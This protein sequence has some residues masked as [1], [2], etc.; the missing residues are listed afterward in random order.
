M[1]PSFSQEHMIGR[2]LAVHHLANRQPVSAILPIVETIGIHTPSQ[3]SLGMVLAPRV[4]GFDNGMVTPL[5]ESGRLIRTLGV[6]GAIRVMSSGEWQFM[7]EELTPLDE[8][9]LLYMVMG[10][11]SLL[12]RLRMSAMQVLNM[13]C[14]VLPT[15]LKDGRMNKTSLGQAVALSIQESLNKSEREIWSWPSF[16]YQGQ[17]LGESLVRHLL[18][19]AALSVPVRLVDDPKSNGF[20]YTIGSGDERWQSGDGG[21]LVRRFLHAY[22]PADG[23][24]FAMWAR[25]SPSHASRL[26]NRI[27]KEELVKIPGRDKLDWMLVTDVAHL[28]DMILP[29]GIRF[30][31][32]YDPFLR[33]PHRS[34]LING[35]RQYTY[36]FR[37]AGS[38]GMVLADGHCVAGWYLKRTKRGCIFHIED[39]GETLGRVAVDE[40]EEE[41]SRMAKAFHGI[42][43]GVSVVKMS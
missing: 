1:Q 32:P 15:V 33:M 22:G 6:R 40:L 18:P 39:I 16:Q 23:E 9:E 10:A 20:L 21:C 41:A 2:I 43:E 19:V 25:I 37:S 38:P 28:E 5:F 27:P 3:D 13:V 34:L 29:E 42:C 14:K 4:D 36:F 12:L 11:K 24:A 7:A 26:W 35:K 30:I 17:T 8:E 31:S